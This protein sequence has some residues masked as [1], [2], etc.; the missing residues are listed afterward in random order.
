MNIFPEKMVLLRWSLKILINKSMS[1]KPQ[2]EIKQI[3]SNCT[4]WKTKQAELEYND[5]YGICTC[6]HWKFVTTENADIRVLDRKNPANKYMNL[7][8]FESQSVVVPIGAV[9][10][11]QYCFVTNENFGCIHFKAK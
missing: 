8:T 5:S 11:S 2:K 9:T 4:N 10:K 1:T 7:H 3:C 6:H